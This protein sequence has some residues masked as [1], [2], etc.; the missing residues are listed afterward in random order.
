MGRFPRLTPVR[1]GPQVPDHMTVSLPSSLLGQHRPP[2]RRVRDTPS[3]DPVPSTSSSRCCPPPYFTHLC[4]PPL[5]SSSPRQ[6]QHPHCCNMQHPL[7]PHGGLTA[8]QGYFSLVPSPSPYQ[9]LVW[10]LV[11]RWG[12]CGSHGRFSFL[13]DLR[14]STHPPSS[15][16][17]SGTSSMLP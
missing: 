11:V 15:W 2:G 5:P 4:A 13:S 1:L 10:C 14:W 12:T 9:R 8:P 16:P 3:L 6:R 17:G 7:T